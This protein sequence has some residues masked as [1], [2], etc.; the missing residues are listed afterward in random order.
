MSEIL[1]MVGL[2][3]VA[4]ERRTVFYKS[5]L[6]QISDNLIIVLKICKAMG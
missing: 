6:W 5:I 4:H 3:S 2:V 1:E